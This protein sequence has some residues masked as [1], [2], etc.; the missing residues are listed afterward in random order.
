MH[1]LTKSLQTSYVNYSLDQYTFYIQSPSYWH[2]G[3][4]VHKKSLKVLIK[5]RHKAQGVLKVFATLGLF[6]TISLTEVM[7]Y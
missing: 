3:F 1:E 4:L 7:Q 2:K 6:M 5:F